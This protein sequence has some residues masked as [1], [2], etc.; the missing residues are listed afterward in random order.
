LHTFPRTYAGSIRRARLRPG[1][2]ATAST[3]W[4][5]GSRTPASAWPSCCGRAAPARCDTRSHRLSGFTGRRSA[6]AEGVIPGQCPRPVPALTC[7][8]GNGGV[9]SSE[10]TPKGPPFRPGATGKGKTGRVNAS[11]P[12]MMPRHV[13]VPPGGRLQ[14]DAGT[15][16][17][18]AAGAGRTA[19]LRPGGHH[20]PRGIEGAHPG[21]CSTVRNVE[22]PTGSGLAGPVG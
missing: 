10:K 12:L 7:A 3:R 17:S 13:W 21:R 19:N 6:D 11:E 1:R 20:R 4:A 8:A 15:G 18:E 5:P 2:K 22:T 9:R 14:R 16:R